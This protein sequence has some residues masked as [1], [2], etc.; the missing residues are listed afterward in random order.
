MRVSCKSL[1]ASTL[2]LVPSSSSTCIKIY[3]ACSSV[4]IFFPQKVPFPS[5]I[6]GFC[7]AAV[8]STWVIGCGQCAARIS[9]ELGPLPNP[10]S[11]QPFARLTG[12]LALERACSGSADHRTLFVQPG[13]HH[14]R[15]GSQKPRRQT[16]YTFSQC[17][18]QTVP[19]VRSHADGGPTIGRVGDHVRHLRISD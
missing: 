12:A 4:T 2:V 19:R 10:A 3:R 17:S 15:Q 5:E 7:V 18:P 9:P 6:N 8:L 1:P 11:R 16:R 13:L 14:R